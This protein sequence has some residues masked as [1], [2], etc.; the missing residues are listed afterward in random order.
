MTKVQKEEP[1]QSRTCCCDLSFPLQ[2][3]KVG[4]A[5]LSSLPVVSVAT[6]SSWCLPF[7]QFSRWGTD[8]NSFVQPLVTVSVSS[9]FAVSEQSLGLFFGQPGTLHCLFDSS[10]WVT[11]RC[12]KLSVQSEFMLQS[13][14]SSV[15]HTTIHPSA[16]DRNLAAILSSLARPPVPERT[17]NRGLSILPPLRPHFLLS[18]PLISTLVGAITICFLDYCSNLLTGFSVSSL[19]SF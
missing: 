11:P 2:F 14:S 1:R 10:T 8:L 19:A 6:Y 3:G 17:R 15:S 7:S 4:H 18:I 9:S 5:L 13:S 16:H 12:H